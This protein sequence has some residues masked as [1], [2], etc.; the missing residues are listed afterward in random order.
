MPSRQRKR[1]RIYTEQME[2]GP[3]ARVGIYVRYSSD[4]QSGHS[5]DTQLRICN[6]YARARQWIVIATFIEPATS[7][8]YDAEDVDHRPQFASAMAA[9]QA[10]TL[11]VLLCHEN[12]R[13]ARNVGASSVSLA[14]LRRFGTWWATADGKWDSQKI[15]QD[16]LD[17]AHVIDAKLNEAF[18]RRLSQKTVAG[19]ESRA[20]QGWHSSNAPFGYLPPL[21]PSPPPFAGVNWRP[22][23]TPVTPDPETWPAL[24]KMAQ[25]CSD[26]YSCQEIAMRLNA[27][28]YRP[29]RRKASGP[30]ELRIDALSRFTKDTVRAILLNPFYREIL[31]DTGKGTITAPSGT[32]VVGQHDAAWDWDTWHQMEAAQGRLR[33]ASQAT[34]QKREQYPFAGLL[35]CAGCGQIVN[36]WHTEKYRYYTCRADRLGLSCP[37]KRR[38]TNARL[39]EEAFGHFLREHRLGESWQADL[40]TL[41]DTTD[42]STSLRGVEQERKK[43]ERRLRNLNVQLDEETIS[44]EEFRGQARMLKSQIESLPRFDQPDKTQQMAV[45]AG[46]QLATLPQA[47]DDAT[48]EERVELAHLLIAPRGL[49]WDHLLHRIV[50]LTPH[51]EFLM[52]LVLALPEWRQEGVSLHR[53]N[54]GGYVDKQPTEAVRQSTLTAEQEGIAL[55]HIASG[56]SIRDVA[57]L[58]GVSRGVVWRVTQRH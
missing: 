14:A 56:L 44:E 23:R 25:W 1:Q 2:P 16:G 19:K 39:V 31:P 24:Q 48:L 47:W 45:D 37:S 6:D 57:Q 5:I 27:E 3:G 21:Y 30:R 33:Y 17:I 7:A 11:Q 9:A 20:L 58:M 38:T 53:P 12:D 15:Q 34:V 50:A 8:K 26:G 55:Q 49:V 46:A 41:L 54:V 22:P 35:V 13:W 43:F 52:P 36:V 51:P 28:G 4:M 32:Q 42:V 10:G 40:A 18:L 29:T